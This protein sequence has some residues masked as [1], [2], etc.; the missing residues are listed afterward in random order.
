MQSMTRRNVVLS[1]AAASAAFGLNKH[2][3]IISPASAQQGGGPSALNPK[4][5]KFHRFKVGDIEV[6]QVFD[7]AVERDHNRGASS[8][9][10]RSTTPRQL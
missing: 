8:A 10:H 1:A 7:G 5:M 4:G 2:L 3:E 6:T 9:M